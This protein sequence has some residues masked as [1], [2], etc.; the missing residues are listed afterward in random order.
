MSKYHVGLQT[1]LPLALEGT[2]VAAEVRRLAALERDVTHHSPLVRVSARAHGAHELL[3][4]IW[5]SDCHCVVTHNSL[6]LKH[7]CVPRIY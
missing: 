7:I 2:Q 4:L 3:A 5:N 1:V 6:P